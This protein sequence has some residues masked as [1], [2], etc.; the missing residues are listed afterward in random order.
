MGCVQVLH[1]QRE[2]VQSPDCS[3]CSD[4]A[5]VVDLHL[6]PLDLLHV[7]LSLLSLSSLSLELKAVSGR[8][9]GLGA[10]PLYIEVASV[11]PGQPFTVHSFF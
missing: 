2:Q 6:L 3:T 5:I 8:D 9:D 1:S 10:R 4:A 11:A 7:H